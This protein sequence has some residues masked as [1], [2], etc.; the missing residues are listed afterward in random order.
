MPFTIHAVDPAASEIFHAIKDRAFLFKS[1]ADLMTE[2]TAAV[3]SRHY[4]K[5][6]ASNMPDKVIR[7]A[8]FAHD[9]LTNA[10]NQANDIIAR[11][12]SVDIVERFEIIQIKIED[13]PGFY[14][15]QLL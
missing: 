10:P 13:A 12:E 8:I 2:A 14:D 6:V 9:P 3:R 15:I 11:Q 7:I 5:V 4:H 1:R